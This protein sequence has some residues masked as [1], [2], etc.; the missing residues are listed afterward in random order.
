MIFTEFLPLIA[1]VKS[2]RT[3]AVLIS[4]DPFLLQQVAT[5]VGPRVLELIL[6]HNLSKPPVP[7][8]AW[9]VHSHDFIQFVGECL[10][11]THRLRQVS[12]GPQRPKTPRTSHT[13]VRSG[14]LTAR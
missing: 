12:P 1:T 14:Y 8:N 4:G 2:W 6:I 11:Q 7:K 10:G 5:V 13:R 3:R 9:Q